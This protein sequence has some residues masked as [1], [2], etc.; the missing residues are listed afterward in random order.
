[1]SDPDRIVVVGASAAGAATVE[2]LRRLGHQGS[3][4]LVGDEPELPYDRPPLSKHLLSGAWSVDRV[5][6]TTAERLGDLDVRPLLGQ[7]AVGMDVPSH[8]VVL[9]DGATIAADAVVIATGSRAR[10]PPGAQ[11][12]AGVHTLRTLGDALRLR[13]ALEVGRSMTVLGGGFLG[14]EIAAVAATAGLAVTLVSRTAPLEQAVGAALA[15]A[16]A[17]VHTEHGVHL[18]I[19]PAA[20]AVRAGGDGRPAVVLDDGRTLTSDLVVWATGATPTVDW[21]TGGGLSL[22]DGVLC[23]A[24]LSAA[25]GVFAVGDV[26]RWPEP[27]TG[28]LRRIQ[29]RL[30]AG[31][32]AAVAAANVLGDDVRHAPVPFWWSD[33]YD[34]RIQFYG[35]PSGHAQLWHGDLSERKAVVLFSADGRVC[36]AAGWNS[37]KQL[38]AARSLVADRVPLADVGPTVALSHCPDEQIVPLGR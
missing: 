3:I 6:L 29:H 23:D 14:M 4:T 1:M 31:E 35:W 34:S 19:G 27:G 10:R 17:G 15:G 36:G 8:T 12:V 20:C 7:P 21:L 13:E 38:R 32:S 30:H 25:P 18:E 2:E 5:I 26:A 11:A 22:E 9:A 16:L 28:R 24:R 37:A 33:Q